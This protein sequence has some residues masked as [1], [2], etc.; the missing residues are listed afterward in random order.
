MPHTTLYDAIADYQTARIY[1]IIRFRFNGRSRTLR[2]NVTL[3]EAQTHCQREDTHGTT[4]GEPW[5]DGFDYMRG[6][7][8]KS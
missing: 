1:R 2:N 7:A 8:P 5:F 4:N 6:C 3:V